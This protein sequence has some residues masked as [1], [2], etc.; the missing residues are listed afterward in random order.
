M[1]GE[2]TQAK[3]EPQSKRE[4][5]YE[6]RQALSEGRSRGRAVRHY[7]EALESHR[8]KQGRRRTPDGMRARIAKIDA[9]LAQA[10]ALQRL[11]LTQERADLNTKL[12]AAEA[13]SD[14]SALEDEFVAVAISYSERH[15]ISYATW[16]SVG[17]P[18]AV[19]KR[20]GISRAAKKS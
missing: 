1:Y 7:L 13:V 9:E 11:H 12:E 10:S 19:L 20:A 4:L 17:V 3:E 2:E 8:P 16:R 5:T 18:A 6:H 15:G 14:I